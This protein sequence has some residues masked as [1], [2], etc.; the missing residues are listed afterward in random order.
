MGG[1]CPWDV[2]N[3]VVMNSL[4]NVLLDSIYRMLTE[5]CFVFFFGG[6]LLFCFVVFSLSSVVT[7]VLG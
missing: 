1:S 6:G 7:R 4:F 5:G 3:L 2:S